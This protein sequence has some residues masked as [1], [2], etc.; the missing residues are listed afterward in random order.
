LDRARRWAAGAGL[1]L[2][3]ALGLA[4][5]VLV[6]GSVGPLALVVGLLLASAPAPLY[7]A[8]ILWIDRFEAEPP[9]LL[10]LAFFLGATI[11]AFV[12]AAINT[13][14]SSR[15]A[16]PWGVVVSG[17][18]VEELAKGAA[19]LGLLAWRR[20][21][22]DGPIDGV[23]YAGMVGLGFA[24][25]EN[26]QYYG[27]AAAT[28]VAPG[29]LFVLRGVLA[30]FAHPLFTAAT[31][32]AFGLALHSR[33]AGRWLLPAV[34]VTLASGL[35]ALWNLAAQRGALLATY[36]GVMV[37][38]FCAGLLAIALELRREGR[39]IA[40]HLRPELAS[41][42]LTDEALA[43]LAS[44]RGRLVARWRALRRE[45]R[46]GWRRTGELHQVIGELAWLRRRT[47]GGPVDE[48]TRAREAAFV[49]EL[50]RLTTA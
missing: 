4:L 18:V 35:H 15:A 5:V 6:G 37:P 8:L 23:V 38:V 17:A 22:C 44:V 26:V 1:L 41:G 46:A 25:V 2:C 39:A 48:A 13:A 16:D 30:P 10:G 21:E 40:E 47:R 34:G 12:A 45:G 49:A 31:G 7:V 3:G 19:L 29:G 42:V 27:L 20:D 9:G 24:T 14:I 36:A 32:A 11:A 43:R 50:V 28:G 33:R